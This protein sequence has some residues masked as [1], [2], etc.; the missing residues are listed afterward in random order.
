MEKVYNSIATAP[1]EP[2]LHIELTGEELAEY[3][4]RSEEVAAKAAADRYKGL[5]Q[6]HYPSSGDQLDAILKQMVALRNSG[7]ALEAD[8]SNIIDSWLH[9]KETYPKGA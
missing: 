5:R 1:G 2:E 6:E 9:V 4:S 8:M 7:V 3:V